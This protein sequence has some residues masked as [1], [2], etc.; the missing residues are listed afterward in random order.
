MCKFAALLRLIWHFEI[1]FISTFGIFR[2][3][4]YLHHN[5]TALTLIV[6]KINT[7]LFL[8]FFFLRFCGLIHFSVEM[9][10]SVFIAIFAFFSNDYE[11][12]LCVF[13]LKC[14]ILKIFFI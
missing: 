12:V 5:I 13:I 1:T 9:F 8:V 10:D 2:S 14:Y 4:Q 11:P 6:R 7:S 3:D